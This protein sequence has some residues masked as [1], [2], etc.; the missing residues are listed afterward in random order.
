MDVNEKNDCL[1]DNP[2]KHFSSLPS[3]NPVSRV[4]AV[5]LYL[6]SSLAIPL[7]FY[8]P[9]VALALWAAMAVLGF[10]LVRS[11]HPLVW[12]ALAASAVSGFLPA[13]IL[14]MQSVGIFVPA[15]ASLAAAI[16]FGL[17]GGTYFQT[18]VRNFGGVAI[19]SV[20]AAGAAWVLG[21]S[22][23]WALAALALLPAVL[24]LSVATNM[25]EYCTTAICYATGGLLVCALAACLIGIWHL[26]GSVSVESVRT[27]LSGWQEKMLGM[28]FA[29]RDTLLAAVEEMR[30]EE[31]GAQMSAYLDA[32]TDQINA[33]MSDEALRLSVRQMIYL[34]PACLFLICAIPAYL[35]QRMLNASYTANGLREVVTPEAEFFTMSLPAAV[36]FALS[37]LLM[38]FVPISAELLY[39]VAS[40]LCV[41]LLPGFLAV[42][43]R[44]LRMRLRG[45]F[46]G[47]MFPLL[48]LV[49]FCCLSLNLLFILAAFGACDRIFSAIRRGLIKKASDENRTDGDDA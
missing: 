11:L 14:P 39:L 43:W 25:G 27:L 41:M 45:R 20:L 29:E 38:L 23:H 46:N 4:L 19:L 48:L 1:Q 8:H 28:Q 42:G 17:L 12:L 2:W 15:T 18:T 36:I 22:W 10:C 44:T 7:G 33:T 37:Y 3:V 34:I 16:C 5:L 24:L 49:A 6:V 30:L 21:G 40:N 9:T 26:T 32:F 47:R 13:L 31:G 35:A